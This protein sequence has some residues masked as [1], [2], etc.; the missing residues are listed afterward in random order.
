MNMV[1]TLF[2][3]PILVADMSPDPAT[4]GCDL[5]PGPDR[6]C[7]AVPWAERLHHHLLSQVVLAYVPVFSA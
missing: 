3:K 4:P 1:G 7:H 5:P 6:H 2:V